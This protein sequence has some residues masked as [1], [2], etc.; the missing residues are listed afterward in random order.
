MQ[1]LAINYI[2]YLH[3]ALKME[4]GRFDGIPERDE[5]KVGGK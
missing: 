1:N 4:K 5:E 2:L 3:E